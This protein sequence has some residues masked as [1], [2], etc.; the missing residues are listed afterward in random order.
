MNRGT[1]TG[2]PFLHDEPKVLGVE[3]VGKVNF[4]MGVT[5]LL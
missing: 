3:F 4:A 2:L 1:R 5:N